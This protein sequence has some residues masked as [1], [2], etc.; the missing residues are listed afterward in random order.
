MSRDAAAALICKL[1]CLTELLQSRA[2]ANVPT[3][4]NNTQ[5]QRGKT[6]ALLFF[7]IKKKIPRILVVHK[8]CKSRWWGCRR[9]KLRSECESQPCLQRTW[10]FGWDVPVSSC[11]RSVLA[12][13]SSTLVSPLQFL[14]GAGRTHFLLALDVVIQGGSPGVDC[15]RQSALGTSEIVTVHWWNQTLPASS[16]LRNLSSLSTSA[17]KR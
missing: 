4:L 13:K 12:K 11:K 16:S 3:A 9:R 6:K 1:G 10:G 15:T 14:S 7:Y 2:R 17:S 5:K 8:N